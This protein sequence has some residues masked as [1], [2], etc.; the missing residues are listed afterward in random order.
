M[1][2]QAHPKEHQRREIP[3]TPFLEHLPIIFDGQVIG[4]HRS[5]PHRLA[6]GGAGSP[7]GDPSAADL[8][9][10][11]ISTGTGAACT[12]SVMISLLLLP[13][14]RVRVAVSKRC[15]STLGARCLTS[16]GCT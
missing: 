9:A 16:S 13:R 10:A 3:G 4:V 8:V 2:Q 7:F 12:I 11:I 6:D 14:M 5:S 1:C 15:A